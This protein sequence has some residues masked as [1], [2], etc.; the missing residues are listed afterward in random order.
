M[1]M[2][3][4]YKIESVWINFWFCPMIL[5]RL[6][7]HPNDKKQKTICSMFLYIEAYDFF[8][9]LEFYVQIIQTFSV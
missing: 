8:K 5:R 1:S 2:E 3:Q 6:R 7:V 9:K 4:S